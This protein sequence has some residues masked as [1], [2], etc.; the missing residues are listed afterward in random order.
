MYFS[1]VFVLLFDCEYD[2][3]YD[4][5]CDRNSKGHSNDDVTV[6]EWAIS[7]SSS[8]SSLRLFIFVI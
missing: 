2:C 5:D 4:C 1:F 7:S 6:M 8:P 3:E